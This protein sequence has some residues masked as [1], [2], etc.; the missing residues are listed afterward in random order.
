M[1]SRWEISS[2]VEVAGALRSVS[3]IVQKGTSGSG[4]ERRSKRSRRRRVGLLG[5]R[6]RILDVYSSYFAEC[7]GT[8]PLQI[9]CTYR[10]NYVSTPWSCCSGA[11]C[12]N[13]FAYVPIC[14]ENVP[15]VF[16]PRS[17]G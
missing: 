8:S 5:R 9:R 17:G 10:E 2:D 3:R 14:I 13:I 6:K 12:K 4:D 16:Q 15:V 11:N 7:M 1:V